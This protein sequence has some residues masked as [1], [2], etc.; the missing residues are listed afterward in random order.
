MKSR[1]RQFVRN[2]IFAQDGTTTVEYAV[3][4]AM[5]LVFC[6]AAILSTGDVQQLLWFDTATKVQIIV[7]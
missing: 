7:P 2:L 4:I 5:I 3:L 1:L 6:V